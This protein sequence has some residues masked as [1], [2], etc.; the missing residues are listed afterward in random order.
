MNPVLSCTTA[1]LTKTTDV[2]EDIFSFTESSKV[3]DHSFNVYPYI[4]VP[5]MFAINCVSNNS[6]FLS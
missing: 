1:L 6:S 5:K 2:A 3:Y 4:Y